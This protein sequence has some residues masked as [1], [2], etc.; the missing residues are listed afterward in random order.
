[1]TRHLLVTNDFP[2]KLGGIQYYL[3]ELWRRLPPEDV[4][5]YTTPY[6]GTAEFDADQA[7]EVHRSVEPV[8]LP[9]PI[10]ARRINALAADV[11][12]DFV[13]LDP[14]L[15][16]GLIGPN[17]DLPYALVIHGA[18]VTVP[19]RLPASKQLLRWVLRGASLTIAAGGYALA[20]AERAAG[21]PLPSVVIPPGV[22]TERFRPVDELTREAVRSNYGLGAGPLLFSVSRLVPR[23]GMDTLI[24]ASAALLDEFPDLQLAIS[25]SGRDTRRLERLI[26][27]TGAPAVLLGRVP[28]DDLP[29]LYAS[30]D[31]FAML[32]RIRWGGLEQEG[33]GI[34]FVEAAAS[35]VAQVAGASGGAAEAVEHGRTGLVVDPGDDVDA[36]VEALGA[37]LRDPERRA[38]MGEQA[39]L[40]ATQIFGYDG[41]ASKLATALDRLGTEALDL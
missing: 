2:P 39:R 32:C 41:L 9:N 36:A 26:D 15:P 16:L 31:L 18:E 1:M 24:R 40:R 27:T 30:A 3:W 6:K 14:A 7:F 5:V 12:A 19:G 35:G 34:V 8:L 23:K 4:V 22:D 10:L 21:R 17:L 37:L 29:A 20:E 28:G 25:G 11:D 38:E 33:F 13:V